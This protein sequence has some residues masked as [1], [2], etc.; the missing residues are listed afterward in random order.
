M[1]PET[2]DNLSKQFP[3]LGAIIFVVGILGLGFN[4]AVKYL[5]QRVENGKMEVKEAL[6]S[7]I[8]E[9]RGEIGTLRAHIERMEGAQREAATIITEARFLAK[10]H[11]HVDIEVLLQRAEELLH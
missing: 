1:N 11:Q 5:D 2:Y 8:E 6:G 9:L 4:F 3:I 7:K 10:H